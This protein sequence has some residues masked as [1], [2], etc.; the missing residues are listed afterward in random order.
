MMIVI[1]ETT[2]HV[3]RFGEIVIPKRTAFI[4]FHTNSYAINL[5]LQDRR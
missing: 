1:V 3:S 2:K 5:C 4:Y